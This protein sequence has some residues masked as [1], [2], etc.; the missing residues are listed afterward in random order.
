M[1]EKTKENAIYNYIQMTLNSWT[2]DR[3]TDAEKKTCIEVL[4][5]AKVSGTYA[6]RWE[7]MHQIYRAYLLGIGYNGPLWREPENS[8]RP[9]F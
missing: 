6:A 7:Q 9:L 4:K 5:Y 1:R 2:Y 3:M 8:G